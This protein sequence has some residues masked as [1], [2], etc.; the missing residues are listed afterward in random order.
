MEK[1]RPEIKQH[2]IDIYL[3]GMVSSSTAVIHSQKLE[4]KNK[5]IIERTRIKNLHDLKLIQDS[6]DFK[7][8]IPVTDRFN[9]DFSIV[10]NSKEIL[11]DMSCSQN[12]VQRSAYAM[13]RS[14]APLSRQEFTNK[15]RSRDLAH[16]LNVRYIRDALEQ[17][18]WLIDGQKELLNYHIASKKSQLAK[19]QYFLPDIKKKYKKQQYKQ[20]EQDILHKIDQ[21]NFQ[22]K[23]NTFPQA[24]FGSKKLFDR[25]KKIDHNKELEKHSKLLEEFRFQR[26]NGLYSKGEKDKK[27][28]A[29]LRIVKGSDI[30][31]IDLKKHPILQHDLDS[32]YLEVKVPFTKENN[33]KTYTTSYR[34]YGKLYRKDIAKFDWSKFENISYSVRILRKQQKQGNEKFEIHVS[35]YR[36]VAELQYDLKNGGIGVDLNSDHTAMAHVA[37]DGNLLKRHSIPHDKLLYASAHKRDHLV[38]EIAHQVVDEAERYRKGIVIENLK[39]HQFLATGRQHNRV[40]SNF[41]HKK[42]LEAMKRLAVRRGVPILHINP[43]FTSITG[44]LKYQAHYQSTIHEAAAFVIGRKGLGIKKEHISRS[45]KNWLRDMKPLDNGKQYSVTS[46]FKNVA[47]WSYINRVIPTFDFPQGRVVPHGNASLD[48]VST[49]KVKNSSNR[50]DDSSIARQARGSNDQYIPDDPDPPD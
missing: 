49:M 13:L 19:I 43:A 16:E 6:K 41:S 45:L 10:P 50:M 39:F 33:G 40:L 42:L 35:V 21:L 12:S 34:I 7:K 44:K 1:P 17:A 31:K 38:H 32:Y 3:P 47:L 29:N 22:K 4:H 18:E 36:P 14:P 2:K 46:E 5:Q 37:A 15:M 8:G 27:G 30:K 26:Q 20:K 28:N 48:P 23:T 24:I 25:L 9:V 11:H